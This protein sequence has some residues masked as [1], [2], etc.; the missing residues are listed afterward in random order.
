MAIALTTING[1]DSIGDSRSTINNNF[2]QLALFV[3]PNFTASNISSKDH[4]VN[5]TDKQIGKV[6]YDS[7]NH[8]LMVASGSLYTSPWYLVDGSLSV[9]PA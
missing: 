7:T 4:A 2:S 6:V 9:T 3:A 1:S 5:T 8:R